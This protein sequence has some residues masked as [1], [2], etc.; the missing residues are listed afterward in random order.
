[1]DVFN[2]H[3]IMAHY[4]SISPLTH[5]LFIRSAFV[6]SEAEGNSQVPKLLSS[7]A[8]R[9]IHLTASLITPENLPCKQGLGKGLEQR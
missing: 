1:M 9:Q 7:L 2:I 5:A 6:F 4:L 3:K 8:K